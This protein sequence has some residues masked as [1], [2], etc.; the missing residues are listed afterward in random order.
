MTLR[1]PKAGAASRRKCGKR[2][3]ARELEKQ[4][5]K[6]E[7]LESLS[8]SRAVSRRDRRHQCARADDVRETPERSRLGGGGDRRGARARTQRGRRYGRATRLRHPQAAI[9]RLRRHRGT[10]RDRASHAAGTM[11]LGEQLAPHFARQVIRSEAIDG[12]TRDPHD[13]RC[14]RAA[15]CDRRAAQ[16]ADRAA[17]PPR[18]GRRRARARQRQWRGT[19]LGRLFRRP[20]RCG[21]GRRRARAPPARLDAEAFRLRARLRAAVHHARHAPRRFA[22]AARH[23]ER[24]VPAAKLRP[25]LQRL[26]Q[27]A[28]GAGREL[29]RAGRARRRDARRRR[30]LRATQCL[31][32]GAA[33][34]RR[35]LRRVAGAR[36]RRCHAARVDQRL[37]RARQRRRLP[38]RQSATAAPR[39]PRASPMRKRSSS[40]PTSWPTT[41]PARA[42]SDSPTRLRPAASRP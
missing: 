29:E 32:P 2:S 11:P 24:P 37:S 42:R 4:W 14:P 41:R 13:A 12:C 38:G 18:R 36:Q 30:A 7:I 6:S 20:V 16:P 1:D 28:H 22:G 33:G 3:R 26:G 27:R 35:L 10:R 19:R 17:R 23:R 15:R 8:Q 39:R 21:G 34:K 5:K 25:P 31:R 40:P 9:A